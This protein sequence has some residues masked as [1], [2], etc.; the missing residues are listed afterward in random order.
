M[1]TVGR[2]FRGAASG[3]RYVEIGMSKRTRE[4]KIQSVLRE[5]PHLTYLEAIGVVLHGKGKTGLLSRPKSKMNKNKVKKGRRRG[6]VMYK[7]VSG[8]FETNRRKH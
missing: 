3:K 1:P 2:S 4:E 7:V 5:E 8:G 6:D